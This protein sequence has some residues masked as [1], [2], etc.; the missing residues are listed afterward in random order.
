MKYLSMSELV[1]F[2]GDEER[3]LLMWRDRVAA[4]QT[5]ATPSGQDLAPSR[6]CMR[7]AWARS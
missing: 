2:C 6:V 5:S 4:G 3:A 1:D 7:A